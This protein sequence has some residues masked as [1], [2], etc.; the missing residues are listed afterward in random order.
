[1]TTAAILPDPADE[2]GCDVLIVEDDVLQAEELA[3]FL[4]RSGLA[5]ET[6]PDGSSG[7]HRIALARPRVAI[8]DY[9]LPGLDGAQVAAQIQSVSPRTAVIM[10][11]GR[12][13]CPS[14]ETLALLGIDAFRNKPLAL[15]PLRNL[16]RQLLRTR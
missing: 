4:R 12:I 3:G 7:L 14:D 2:A 11:S 6:R 8:L 10:V 9:N 16:V 15:A 5:V 13:S 1:M